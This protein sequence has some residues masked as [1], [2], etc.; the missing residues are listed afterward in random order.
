MAG[1]A[2]CFLMRWPLA[3]CADRSASIGR[4]RQSQ[5]RRAVSEYPTAAKVSLEAKFSL[6][7]WLNFGQKQV[8]TKLNLTVVALSDETETIRRI[9]LGRP[10]GATLPG[11]AAGAHL[12][13][14][15]PN[16]GARKYSLINALIDPLATIEPRVYALGIR[17]EPQ[18]DGGSRYM[19]ALTVGALVSGDP[20]QN[21]FSLTDSLEP[22]ALVGGGIGI[23]PLISMAASLKASGRPFQ[24]V[25][26]GRSLAE[27]AF[28]AELKTL[29]GDGLR[30]HTDN[31]AGC[32]FDMAGYFATL[33]EGSKVYMCGPKPMLK[34]GMDAARTLK[35]PRSRLAFELFYSVAPPTP[36]R[37]S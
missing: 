37:P 27:L 22:V 24:M 36:L 32:L 23:T 6:E 11:F 28:L 10:D 5:T 34:A 19:H 15:V 7:V 33:I 14:D 20:P 31:T 9:V 3:H 35:W 21:N 26:A 2:A 12:T 17:N 30:I 16:I 13:I 25:Y 18:G 29:A 4:P 8:M 1:Q